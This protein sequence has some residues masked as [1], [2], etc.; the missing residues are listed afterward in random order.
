MYSV[1][2]FGLCVPRLQSPEGGSIVQLILTAGGVRYS[3]LSISILCR[4]CR[5]LSR[6]WN[7]IIMSLPVSRTTVYTSMKHLF[8]SRDHALLGLC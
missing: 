6:M 5:C 1:F 4:R 8:L 7:E 2:H 3:G